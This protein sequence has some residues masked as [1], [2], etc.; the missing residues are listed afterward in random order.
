MP[1]FD[2]IGDAWSSF[3]A[4]FSDL[5]SSGNEASEYTRLGGVAVWGQPDTGKTTFI[6]RLRGNTPGDEKTQTTSRKMYKN[7]E[8]QTSEDFC[9]RIDEL[10]DIPGSR[11]RLN[12]WLKEVGD[13]S[14][15]FYVVD[16]SKLNDNAYRSKVN[17]DIGKT[18]EKIEADFIAGGRGDAHIKK[19]SIIGTHLDKSPWAA[20]AACD[21]NNVIADSDQMRS[22]YDAFGEVKGVIYSVNLMDNK[23]ANQLI[24]DIINDCIS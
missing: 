8:G 7:I 12:D 10:V 14:N 15:I 20:V 13:K 24:Q 5:F 17:F 4:F 18:I 1:V 16:L 11:D 9:Y 22:I 23:S 21:A 19:V 2:T 3:S 6:S